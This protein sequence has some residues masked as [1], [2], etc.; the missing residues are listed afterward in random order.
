MSS[1][2]TVDNV[3]FNSRA[4]QIV[5]G[6]SLEIEKGTTTALVG[7]SGC[8]K[9]TLLKLIAGIL[10]P[11]SGKIMFEG[12]DI[13]LM[14]R[15]ENLNFRKKCSF[16]FQDSALWANQDIMSNL[17][18]PLMTHFPEMTADERKFTIDSICAMVGYERPLTLRP[19]D[20]SMGEQ[21]KIAFAR[22]MIIG[23]EVLFLDE[24]TESLD[25]KGTSIIMGLLHNYVD[26]G[27]TIIY[28]SHN[29]SFINEFKGDIHT[30]ED[31]LLSKSVYVENKNEI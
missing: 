1:L 5:K 11:S 27:N 18:L 10:V 21:K 15:V 14:N 24:C 8:G 13:Q 26:Q 30:L 20:L 3:T 23:P 29:S 16:V 17:S 2:F 9:S 12:K 28:V 7:K 6:I 22:A 31:G 4:T 25:R 19:S